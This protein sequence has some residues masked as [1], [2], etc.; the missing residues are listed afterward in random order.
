L[1]PSSTAKFRG[2]RSWGL[3][4][5]LGKRWAFPDLRRLDLVL[6]FAAFER[7]SDSERMELA[8]QAS[9]YLIKEPSASLWRYL[10]YPL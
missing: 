2:K 1:G 6:L 10:A 9:S 7:D 8:L 5:P 4:Q 3:P